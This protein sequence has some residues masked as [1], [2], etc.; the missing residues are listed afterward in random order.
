MSYVMGRQSYRRTK[1]AGLAKAYV[2]SWGISERVMEW[3]KKRKI[4]GASRS[5]N[6]N[7]NPVL[8][9]NHAHVC[10]LYL[11]VVHEM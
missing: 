11:P 1:V 2:D 3:G 4:T 9:K 5:N 8:L 10:L 7:F 6:M